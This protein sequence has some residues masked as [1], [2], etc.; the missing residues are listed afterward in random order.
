[1]ASSRT[2]HWPRKGARHSTFFDRTVERM[3][4]GE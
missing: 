2:R 1:M 4:V 3:P